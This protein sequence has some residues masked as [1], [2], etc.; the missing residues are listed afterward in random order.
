MLDCSF[1]RSQQRRTSFLFLVV[2][3]RHR[4]QS[5]GRVREDMNPVRK[6]KVSPEVLE[7]VRFIAGIIVNI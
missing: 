4:L 3:R 5:R 6:L 7:L 1:L 2:L